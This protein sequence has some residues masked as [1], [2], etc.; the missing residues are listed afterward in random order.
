MRRT[1]LG[2]IS[3]QFLFASL[4]LVAGIAAPHALEEQGAEQEQS[5]GLPVVDHF[6]PKNV[7]HQPVPQEHHDPAEH[8]K[9]SQPSDAE[10]NTQGDLLRQ[11]AFFPPSLFITLVMVKSMFFSHFSPFPAGTRFFNN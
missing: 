11:A 10:K 8:G 4:I 5:P 3:A 9:Q 7:G 1:F 6:Q 2:D